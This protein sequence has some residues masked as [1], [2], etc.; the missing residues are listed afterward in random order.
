VRLIALTLERLR[1]TRVVAQYH[2]MGEWFS[3]EGEPFAY[4][5][6]DYL[7]GPRLVDQLKR[8]WSEKRALDLVFSLCGNLAITHHQGLAIGDFDDGNNVILVGGTDP[9]FCDIGLGPGPRLNRNYWADINAL[10]TIVTQL[11]RRCRVNG[12]L[13]TIDRALMRVQ[14]GRVAGSTTGDILNWVA[15][16]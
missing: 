8:R 16:L 10:G 2:H 12:Q 13:R 15:D 4:I 5:V 6:A 1:D 7:D 3:R 14:G 9:V 11:S